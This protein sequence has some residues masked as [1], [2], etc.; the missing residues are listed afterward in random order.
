M[1][2][3][4]KVNEANLFYIKY[5]ILPNLIAFGLAY[6]YYNNIKLDCNIWQYFNSVFSLFNICNINMQDQFKLVDNILINKYHLMI[7]NAYD[8]E[9]IRIKK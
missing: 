1:N 3:W 2:N 4:K 5:N 8:L 9:I 7:I 6:S